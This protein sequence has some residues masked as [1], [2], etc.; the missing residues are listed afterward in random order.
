MKQRETA[1]RPT[2]NSLP[3]IGHTGRLQNWKS[4]VTTDFSFFPWI[5]YAKR[6]PFAPPNKEEGR[7]W[8][9]RVVK[10]DAPMIPAF[11][12]FVKP[13]PNHYNLTKPINSARLCIH[14]SNF[15]L[16]MFTEY[17]QLYGTCVSNINHQNIANII[18]FLTSTSDYLTVDIV[19][20]KCSPLE[21]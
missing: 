18:T 20:D 11:F 12:T 7:T 21:L 9:G 10:V 2:P 4:S 14:H 6:K 19:L 17:R 5:V 15:C 3:V 16:I 1:Y 13:H 8:W